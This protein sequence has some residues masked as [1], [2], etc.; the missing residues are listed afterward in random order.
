MRF[1]CLADPKTVSEEKIK[2]L[3][4]A[5]CT[6]IIIGIQGSEQTNLNIYHRNQK[7]EEVLRAA[8]ILKVPQEIRLL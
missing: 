5:G 4:E 8:R 1:K 3:V 6:D 7:D 2:L